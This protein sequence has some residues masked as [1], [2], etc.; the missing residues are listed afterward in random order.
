MKSINSNL[1]ITADQL[2]GLIKGISSQIV[3]TYNDPGNNPGYKG[4]DQ[5]ASEKTAQTIDDLDNFLG[6]EMKNIKIPEIEN[7]KVEE[8]QVTEINSKFVENV[9]ENDLYNLEMML[10]N[11]SL[12]NKSY[13]TI[14]DEIKKRINIKRDQFTMLPGIPVEEMNSLAYMT[15]LFYLLTL[16]NTME[17]NIPIPSSIPVFK[18]KKDAAPDVVDV[19]IDLFLFGGYIRLLRRRLE[20]KIENPFENKSILYLQY[21]CF[22]DPLIFS[23]IENTPEDTLESIVVSR[24]K[25]YD[26]KLAIFSKYT[27]LLV[28][29][30]CPLIKDTDI[31]AYVREVQDKVIN[32]TPLILELHSAFQA[33]KL[34]AKNQFSLEQI[35]NEVIPLEFAEKQ[36]KDLK[37]QKVLDE[38]KEKNEIS[39]EILSFFLRKEPKAERVKTKK[40]SNLERFVRSFRDDIPEGAREEFQNYIKEFENKNFDFLQCPF[41]IEEFGENIIK[42]LYNW[43]PKD[44]EKISKHYKYFYEKV[45]NE[46]MTKTSILSS[47]KTKTDTGD[48]DFIGQGA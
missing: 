45:E 24:Y 15:R 14:A 47:V 2:P 3:G 8:K 22:L 40:E 31:A 48:W 18:Y 5:N 33:G 23:F 36:G 28:D 39:D 32:K 11:A 1:Y 27:T 9:L 44:D 29:N 7:G 25:Y 37:D 19:A 43:K 13:L 26:D 20:D 17:R 34:P 46:I 41:N 42:G 4:G 30:G 35:V 10:N 38:I 21:R 16:H 12:S 6:P